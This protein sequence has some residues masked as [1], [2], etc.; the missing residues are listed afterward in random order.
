M[1]LLKPTICKCYTLQ[2]GQELTGIV[3][4]VLPGVSDSWGAQE[5]ENALRQCGEGVQCPRYF[6][7]DAV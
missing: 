4:C 6:C 3:C 1:E 5:K 2:N 7:V